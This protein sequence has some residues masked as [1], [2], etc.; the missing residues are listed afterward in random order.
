MTTPPADQT[1]TAAPSA[2]PAP[3]GASRTPTTPATPQV[4]PIGWGA[5]LGWL[6]RGARDMCAFWGIALFYGFCFWTMALILGAVFR[7]RP[8]YTMSIVSGCLLVGPFL[9]MGLYDVSRRRELGDTPALSHS[10]TCWDKHVGSM[11]LLVLVLMVLEL[12]WGRA[13][14]VVFA[15]FF[16]TGMPS[17]TGVLQ[18]I[19]SAGN[20]EF[21]LVYMAVGEFLPRWCSPPWW[22]QCP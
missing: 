1:A 7:S 16:K 22:C 2:I 21:V 20:W 18:A 17:T 9:A 6:V 3:D 8:E 19:F 10:I 4:R 5:P 14:L 11:G 15:V 13:S 12:L